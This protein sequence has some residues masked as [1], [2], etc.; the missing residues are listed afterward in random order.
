MSTKRENQK[1]PTR[2][3]N[4]V[5]I[6][7]TKMVDAQ[8]MLA[9]QRAAVS[10]L[11]A[12][13][14]GACE[15]YSGWTE[16]FSDSDLNPLRATNFVKLVK[17]SE[18]DLNVLQVWDGQKWINVQ[19]TNTVSKV[20]PKPKVDKVVKPSSKQISKKSPIEVHKTQVAKKKYRDLRDGLDF[21]TKYGVEIMLLSINCFKEAY[22]TEQQKGGDLGS[23]TL[24]WEDCTKYVRNHQSV[25][26]VLRPGWKNALLKS[27]I[28]DGWILGRKDKALTVK[29]FSKGIEGW[30]SGGKLH[31]TVLGEAPIR[32]TKYMKK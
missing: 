4:G 7:L 24:F 26:S 1:I 30:P 27:L 14:K 20:V 11:L 28:D 13:I 23:L 22:Q 8:K 29:P 32:I 25:G 5:D 15:E 17:Q 10:K 2:E 3:I 9:S 16:E 31:P 19:L 21:K 6:P 12:T 18:T